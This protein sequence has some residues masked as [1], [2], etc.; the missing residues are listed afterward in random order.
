MKQWLALGILFLAIIGMSS[1]SYDDSNDIDIITPG[2][3]TKT[4][5]E[6][7]KKVGLEVC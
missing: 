7:A 2:D 1:C 5:I 4:G 3:S 6:V